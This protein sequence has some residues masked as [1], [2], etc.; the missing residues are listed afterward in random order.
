MAYRFTKILIIE[1]QNRKLYLCIYLKYTN[2]LFIW[3]LINDLED[4][5]IYFASPR[6]KQKPKN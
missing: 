4:M 1:F 3:N 6:T 2:K 5:W